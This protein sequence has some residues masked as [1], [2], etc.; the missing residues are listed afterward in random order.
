MFL[1]YKKD[2]LVTNKEVYFDFLFGLISYM[3][4]I[5]SDIS[6]CPYLLQNFPISINNNNYLN[7]TDYSKC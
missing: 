1:N 7:A 4:N 3:N 2:A 6:A 5:S